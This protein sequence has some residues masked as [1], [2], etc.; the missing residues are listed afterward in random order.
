MKHKF[1]AV[2]LAFASIATAQNAKFEAETT[3]PY[4]GLVPVIVKAVHDGDSYKVEF[5][6]GEKVW[7]RL[8]GVDCPEVVSNHIMKDQPW[9]RA[10]A[11]SVRLLIK[12]D[13]VYLDTMAVKKHRDVYGRLLA[14]V[15]L[16]DA[17][18]LPLHLVENGWAFPVK[19]A[20][21]KSPS[22]NVIL[23]AAFSEA[24]LAKRAIF[25]KKNYVY[26]STWRAKY[27]H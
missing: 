3:F 22:T 8:I 2:L 15:Y 26:P 1:L 4:Q 7:I 6:G 23:A 18:F 17:T 12:H 27:W 24:R 20:S 21:R 13:T 16:K 10:I 25:M 19:V 11:D 9:G 5:S 14:E